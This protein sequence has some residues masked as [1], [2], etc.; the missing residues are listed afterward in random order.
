MSSLKR[1]TNVRNGL[2]AEIERVTAETTN[3]LDNYMI[4]V[5][6]ELIAN[7]NYLKESLAELKRLDGEILELI[8]EEDIEK[9]IIESGKF[10]SRHRVVVT[11]VESKIRENL[12]T[13]GNPSPATKQRTVKL[14]YLQLKRF[15]G[16]PTEWGAFWDAFSSSIDKSEELDDVQKFNYLKS[17]LHGNAARALDGLQSTN[18]NYAEAV[19]MLKDRFGNKQVVIS[20]HMRKFD[21]IKAIKNIANLSGLRELYDQVESNVRS[22]QSV[23]V[24]RESYETCLSPKVLQNLPEE[25]RI[26]LM[27][28][29]EGTWNL[30]LLLKEFKNEL[31]IREKCQFAMSG[32][33]RKVDENSRGSYT[34]AARSPPRQSQISAATLLSNAD[35]RNSNQSRFTPRC[36]FCEG[37]HPSHKCTVVTD[38]KTRRE[39]VKRKGRCYVCLKGGHPARR[40]N[41]QV[42]CYKCRGRHHATIC[43]SYEKGE[44]STQQQSG[45]A[46]SR[47]DRVSCASAETQTTTNMHI[48]GRNSVLLQTARADVSAPGVGGKTENI[49]IIFDSGSQKTYI[50][51][52]LKK[53]LNLKVV[54]KD[55]L[56]IKTFG[57]ETPIT[58]ECEIVQ[59]AV[60]S[61]DGMEIYVNAY[62]VPNICS[63]ITNQVMSIA[64][65]NYDYLR[66]LRLA[67]YSPGDELNADRPVDLLVGADNF[68]LFVEDGIIRG[69]GNGP[70]AM[71]TKLGWV[72]SGPVQGVNS[73]QN[74]HCFRV[75][76]EVFDRE[77]DPTLNQLH[78]FRQA[79]S[80]SCEKHTP[81]EEKFEA[82][83]EFQNESYDGKN[84]LKQFPE[85]W[86]S[87]K[88]FDND[89]KEDSRL[90]DKDSGKFESS[91]VDEGSVLKVDT[92]SNCDIHALLDVSR[93]SNIQKLLRIIGFVLRFVNNLRAK[94]AGKELM[95]GELIT[96]ETNAALIVLIKSEQSVLKS[97]ANFKDLKKNLEVFGDE[98]GVLRCK[99][100][101]ENAPLPYE[102]R[103]PILIPRDREIAKLLVLDAHQIVKHEG[104]K[105]TLAQL[106]SQYWIVRGRQY[107][108]KIIA[109]FR[110]EYHTESKEYHRFKRSKKREKINVGDVV[111][112]FEDK[113]PRQRWTLGRVEKLLSS[114]DGEIRSAVVRVSKSGRKSGTLRR[115]I[116]RLYPVEVCEEKEVAVI[117]EEHEVRDED[118]LEPEIKFVADQEVRQT[119]EK[120][121]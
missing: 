105:E 55:R 98:K 39:I 37:E 23:G 13:T 90:P 81:V 78:K 112:I 106:R 5:K 40:C 86:P 38:H 42:N 82:Q 68:W 79:E 116:A 89:V 20:S 36:V 104:V 10:A 99:G 80:V 95:K 6:D 29:L 117:A 74:S 93:H 28:K 26:S 67:D 7:G 22:L 35:R 11:K 17:Y 108:R 47:A 121:K 107:V 12:Q 69:E 118:G 56:L 76:V 61:L 4:E 111:T 88:N 57:D 54:G 70:V 19:E 62:V 48:S 63:P 64:V 51:E 77:V 96:D 71:K 91:D 119:V 41:S 25:L 101:I 113:I 24:S 97:S 27:R 43:E 85:F 31:Q 9:D 50:N 44:Q 84:E 3:L 53:S 2:R 49:R 60:K 45:G 59:I 115:P 92:Q 33:E 16:N 110:R 103:F 66:D 15:G 109:R 52:R 87:H 72:V 8:K 46:E 65:E 58:K 14:P 114:T 83:T 34:T 94:I 120:C 100:R 75:D 1:K 30:D 21:E 73:Y 32:A 18:E 102:T